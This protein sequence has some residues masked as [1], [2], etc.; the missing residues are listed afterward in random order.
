MAFTTVD[1]GTVAVKGVTS[2]TVTTAV[3]IPAG[4]VVIVY[5]FANNTVG[6]TVTVAGSPT[7]LV[8]YRG[9]STSN[10]GLSVDY[11]VTPTGLAAGTAIRSSA[12]ASAQTYVLSAFYVTGADPY[13]PIDTATVN[14]GSAQSSA[15]TGSLPLAV[16]PM[17]SNSLILAAVGTDGP[18]TDSFTQ[19][20]GWSD[21]P[22]TRVGTTGGTDLTVAG[23]QIVASTQINY[24]ASFAARNWNCIIFAV[25]P[26]SIGVSFYDIGSVNAKPG[27]TQI[28]PAPTGGVP[29][30][31]GI[32]FQVSALS[33]TM[34]VVSVSDNAG[35]TYVSL[36]G[37]ANT[38]GISYQAYWCGNSKGLPF[39]QNINITT[40][41]LTEVSS[42]VFVSGYAPGRNPSGFAYN[43][44]SGNPSVGTGPQPLNA[45]QGI[46]NILA[47]NGPIGDTFTLDTVNGW[48]TPPLTRSGTT[49]AGAASNITHNGAWLTN[50]G[51]SYNDAPT[52]GTSRPYSGNHWAFNPAIMQGAVFGG[53]GAVR[54]DATIRLAGPQAFQTSA[55]ING[56]GGVLANGI[57]PPAAA[58]ALIAGTGGAPVNYITNP[59][60]QGAVVGTPGTL[61]T[62]WQAL[63][64]NGTTQSVV[65]SGVQADGTPYCDIR[66]SG[67]PTGT[68]VIASFNGTAA[69][70]I[71]SVPSN[72]PVTISAYMAMVGGSLANITDG[73]YL[74]I[75]TNAAPI[76]NPGSTFTPTATL[77]RYSYTFS[78]A[79]QSN[80]VSGGFYFNVTAGLPIDITL[81]FALPQLEIGPVATAPILPAL[82]QYAAQERGIFANASGGRD[83][84]PNHFA[85]SFTPNAPRQNYTGD[86]GV[87]FTPAVALTFNRIGIRCPVAG[88][89]IHTVFIRDVTGN[90]VLQ[91][92]T[93]DL[94]GATPG[95]YY[96]TTLPQTTLTAGNVYYLATTVTASDGQL[97]AD[98]G[99]TMLRGVVGGSVRCANSAGGVNPGTNVT[100]SQYYGLD[101]DL[102]TTPAV[103]NALVAGLGGQTNYVRNPRAEGAV[104]G[105]IGSGGAY[106]TYWYP[107]DNPA[108]PGVTR[109]IVA[110]GVDA[111]TGF[112]YVD[113][114][115]SGTA[116]A[117]NSFLH[118]EPT[119]WPIV[120][121]GDTFT[122][123]AW[124]ALVGGSLANI[125]PGTFY[126]VSNFDVG[127]NVV[128]IGTLLNATLTAYGS[129]A[130][131][132]SG[133]T[134]V[135]GGFLAWNYPASGAVDFTIRI[136]ATQ[137]ERGSVRT[138]I[139]YPPA[140]APNY[141]TRALIAAPGIAINASAQIDGT[142][143]TT[144]YIRNPRAINAAPGT[145]GTL[146]SA[147]N[148]ASLP[149]QLT[150]QVV[151][152]GLDAYTG[153]NYIDVRYSGTTIG[154]G[155][156]YLYV[157]NG[158]FPF[159]GGSQFI[160]TV[161]L[162][163][164]GGTLANIT[165]LYFVSAFQP[166][167]QIIVSIPIPSVTAIPSAWGTTGVA[168]SGTRSVQGGYI[169]IVYA[170]GAVDFTL[171]ISGAQLERGS[172][173]T[174]LILP[175][176]GTWA[177]TTRALL[178]AP[179]S[180]TPTGATINGTG[181]VSATIAP[182][183]VPTGA[184]IAG[185]EANR[186]PLL[187]GV[188]PVS[189]DIVPPPGAGGIV[190]KHTR[191]GTT[192]DN[193]CGVAWTNGM[194]LVPYT[195]KVMVWIPAGWGGTLVN[196]TTEGNV[197]AVVGAPANLSLTN[198]W[199]LVT[200]HAIR[201][202]GE[203]AL[204]ARINDAT[205]TPIYT[206]AWQAI[207]DTVVA[208]PTI[209]GSTA[210]GG[211]GSVTA[212][213]Y[214]LA[215]AG[216]RINAVG[217]LSV[218]ARNYAPTG[219]R[220]DGVG[221]FRSI[222]TAPTLAQT[223][224]GGVGSVSA[225]AVAL[226]PAAAPVGGRNGT[227][228]YVLNPRWVGAALG[229][230][231]VGPV[232]SPPM[233]TGWTCWSD[234]VTT[235]IVGIGT[236]DGLD[237]IDVR[238][239]GTTTNTLWGLNPIHFDGPT[240]RGDVWTVSFHLSVQSGNTS[241]MQWRIE[242]QELDANGGYVTA[243]ANNRSVFP[244]GKLIATRASE[245]YTIS[246]G[247]TRYS[248]PTFFLMFA[249]GQAIDITI[250]LACMQ[251]ELGPI[252]TPPI[253]PPPGVMAIATRAVLAM[254]TTLALPQQII[255]GQ[256][257]K[258]NYITNPRAEGAV[259][260]SPGTL[261][262][263]WFNSR[264][265]GLTR[266]I[267]GT[268]TE[269]GIPY[270]DVRLSGTSTD[271]VV[272]LGFTGGS[273]VRANINDVVSVSAFLKIVGGDA[274][275]II[276]NLH[277]QA[278]NA[279]GF[280]VTEPYIPVTPFPGN[281]SL[282][283]ARC[284]TITTFLPVWVGTYYTRPV[285]LL[286]FLSEL[287]IDV[288]LRIGA[289]QLE[290]RN[291]TSLMLPPVGAPQQTMRGVEAKPNQIV[292]ASARIAGE[293]LIGADSTFVGQAR[294]NAT[295]A[296]VGNI[297]IVGL[298]QFHAAHAVIHGTGSVIVGF[299]AKEAVKVRLLGVG[300]VQATAAVAHP[301]IA[302]IRGVGQI[303]AVSQRVRYGAATIAGNSRLYATAF[304]A[305]SGNVTIAGAGLLRVRDTIIA[306]LQTAA[307]T[308]TG[309]AAVHVQG[310]RAPPCDG[311][312]EAEGNVYAT[313]T[314][315]AAGQALV[316]GAGTVD[317]HGT[318]WRH[319]EALL[320]GEGE[321]RG[322]LNHRP[323]ASAGIGGVGQV[324]ADG[325]PIRQTLGAAALIAGVGRVRADAFRAATVAAEALIAGLGAI[326]AIGLRAAVVNVDKTIAGVGN[327][328]A[329][330]SRVIVAASATI[331][332]AGNLKTNATQIGAHNAEAQIDG[333]S[334][335]RVDSVTV[336]QVHAAATIQGV[337]GAVAH[338]ARSQHARATIAGASS[339]TAR[340]SVW[341][342]ALALI[343]GAGA[344]VAGHRKAPFPVHAKLGGAGSVRATA[345]VLVST[346]VRI[347]GHATVSH[348]R[349]TLH[350]EAQVRISVH[351]WLIER[352]KSQLEAHVRIAGQGHL[353]FDGEQLSH[354]HTSARIRGVGQ[355]ETDAS[356]PREQ[357]A[358]QGVY[359]P[360]QLVGVSVL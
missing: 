171:R 180:F 28:I 280:Y 89:G 84:S 98:Q 146:P 309:T 147:W 83:V 96:Y 97:W 71:S 353:A 320:D 141:S 313:A 20:S 29:V 234:T 305:K 82:T 176:V 3:D 255:A 351:G 347:A 43:A 40:S 154:I 211:V 37:L 65:G 105:V 152:V 258:T 231:A 283:Q 311:L 22:P 203:V 113:V 314:V 134:L 328:R 221:S 217:S 307:A 215:Q 222:G 352:A 86:V 19:S 260:G 133:A 69:T 56:A 323:V 327:V 32:F 288:T 74:S 282:D 248:L 301:T 254:P 148:V 308:I 275:Q 132:P 330:V 47:V 190:F 111:G 237:Y 72:V 340:G 350:A 177:L 195:F 191:V 226:R 139:I 103:A 100:D 302:R 14:T 304:P 55:R 99:P 202:T 18:I 182:V 292:Q 6:H 233:P 331:A 335:L 159:G 119:Y 239:A 66:F 167:G 214:T 207:P 300:G 286:R 296:G 245:T 344:F 44:A 78:Q 268:G 359:L 321:V 121:A 36:G 270:I 1:L 278:T 348:V 59:R 110:T 94:T 50:T 87:Q 357:I 223:T 355:I 117:G 64:L 131:A 287:A 266:T 230:V 116:V 319:A 238:L 329:T 38:Q 42:A 81:R 122:T 104:L 277:A 289:P 129:T 341:V 276:F 53:A 199:Q 17:L 162:S 291:T 156:F 67:T 70:W 236:E 290:A 4:A 62:A 58:S 126:Y 85:L 143:G 338:A 229:T 326:V 169:Q 208:A 16:V 15:S 197:S 107:S 164:S 27:T 294:A 24:N 298:H 256:G 160:N 174:P 61:P 163:V 212:S 145:P 228:N 251:S 213:A 138:S 306:V 343:A 112:A 262:T 324:A 155:Q 9:N 7:V 316:A 193:N 175:P 205:A 281:A 346:H 318:A 220:I 57:K 31:A 232:Q 178:A 249:A 310:R 216:A 185:G 124:L 179:G 244:T 102:V 235:T 259:A 189:T 157:E 51:A 303:A 13:R 128:V 39:G 75:R 246:N 273:E 225:T 34:P 77:T 198:Q 166:T 11:Y 12:G 360:P 153:C 108:Q 181:S 165:N 23:G 257:G 263:G 49:G 224:I 135:S 336:T 297:I 144:N 325:T 91:S 354:H 150:Q 172:V 136:A 285:V 279:N 48:E 337:G 342:P 242:T 358:S 33:T 272:D 218:D 295:L 240:T 339:V 312:I 184:V 209:F 299:A 73:V 41:S 170:A 333:S 317:A 93:I 92:A 25:R 192:G 76:L 183:A 60:A 188:A 158:T 142:G 261:P 5:T 356:K 271:V 8:V 196:I 349:A 274:S 194:P 106:P 125:P 269:A 149:A 35:N 95:V 284:A 247:A 161:W 219:A 30:G 101:L 137:L 168:P 90:A 10:Y 206:A 114:R 293:G 151:G 80:L 187:Q 68:Y 322:L 173:R 264:T 88:T 186:A 21:P 54:A 345:H 115:V 201:P 250:R 227:T 127:N 332:G 120:A 204:V 243:T 140:G 2:A 123:T 45:G 267:V 315:R 200:G 241:Q 265:S 26:A 109:Q 334:W 118:V 210:L 79:P 253:L 130:A 52:L 46:L 252:A 63:T